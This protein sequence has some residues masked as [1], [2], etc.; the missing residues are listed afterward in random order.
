MGAWSSHVMEA[1]VGFSGDAMSWWGRARS[2]VGGNGTA[3]G[4]GGDAMPWWGRAQSPVGGNGV[5]A[6]SVGTPCCGGKH[7]RGMVKPRGGRLH[8]VHM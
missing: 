8:Y 3:D 5:A 6:G 2:P 1:A 7:C 4:S